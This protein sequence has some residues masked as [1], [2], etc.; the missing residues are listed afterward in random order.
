MSSI[1]FLKIV[2]SLIC[3]EGDITSAWFLK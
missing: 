1:I 2:L 3:M